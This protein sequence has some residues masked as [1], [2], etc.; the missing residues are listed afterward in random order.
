MRVDFGVFSGLSPTAARPAYAGGDLR[1][2][3][4]LVDSRQRLRPCDPAHPLLTQSL[5]ESDQ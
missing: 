1:Q 4:A 2:R 3:R 5:G